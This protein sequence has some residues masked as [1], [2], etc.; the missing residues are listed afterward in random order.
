MVQLSEELTEMHAA[1]RA[2]LRELP[3]ADDNAMISWLKG[4]VDDI[5]T[6]SRSGRTWWSS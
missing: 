2:V 1:L 3:D 5:D 4:G 6:S